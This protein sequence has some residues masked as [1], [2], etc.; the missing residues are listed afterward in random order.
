MLPGNPFPLGARCHD[1]GVNFAVFSAHA[2]RIDVLVFDRSG[3]NELACCTLPARTGDIFHGF[4]PGGGPG[5][6]YGLRAY[7]PWDPATGQRFDSS[8]LLL[9]PYAREIVETKAFKARVIDDD[10]DWHDDR[11]PR[12]AAND[13]LLYELHIKGQSQRNLAIP[14]ELR[15]SF[16]GLAH[17]ESIR[18]LQALGVTTVSLLPVQ[19]HLDEQR[20]VDR[21]LLNYW[22]YNTLGF[23]CPSPRLASAAARAAIDPGRAIRDEFRDMVRALHAAGI[24][25]ILDIVF[26]HTCES[27]EN[28][29]TLSWRGLDNASWY[30]LQADNRALY[31]NDTGCGNTLN[32]A[33][34]QV[35]QFVI[36]VLR[37]W[38][39]EMHV[40]GFRFDLA[41][42]LARTAQGFDPC[43]P[44]LR[45]IAGDPVLGGIKCIAEPWDIGPGGYQLGRFPNSW[46]E[47]NDRFRDTVRRY[48]VRNDVD[49]GEFARRLCGSA[50]LFEHA[51]RLPAASV[52][53]VVSHDG[54]TLRD[55]VSYDMRHNEA[56]GEANRDGHGENFSSNFGIEGDTDDLAILKKRT[57]VQRALLATLLLAQGTPMLAAG[58]EFGATQRGNN[59]PYCQDNDISWLD[60]QSA[61]RELIHFCARVVHIRQTLRPLAANW[62][63]EGRAGGL[64]WCTPEGAALEGMAWQDPDMHAFYVIINENLLLLFNP[65][66]S[67]CRFT[68]PPGPWELLLDSAATTSADTDFITVSLHEVCSSS[69]Q[70]LRQISPQH[71][72]VS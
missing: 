46:Y 44:L 61:D 4:L 32:T 70:L 7:G 45:A 62:Y 15:G 25:V 64:Q 57:R 20:L 1:E 21:D 41:T 48:W 58:S 33:H 63:V 56:N 8:K 10:Y 47:W 53:Y 3:T 43:A 19:Q 54:F 71:K 6:V 68:L 11:A 38:V 5:L 18:H 26:N 14:A 36:D 2:T 66:P 35:S 9:D 60:W 27:D 42:T 37:F 17:I 34:P 59:N 69:L 31:V 12:H 22:G 24:E 55:L 23:F 30:R 16:L 49:R 72:L 52:N 28:G 65:S 40:D 29:P 50:D 67:A 13:T 51:G 39:T